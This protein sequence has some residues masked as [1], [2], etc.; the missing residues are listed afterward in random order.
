M[1]AGGTGVADSVVNQ[2]L[3]KI[4]GVEALNNVFLIG[5]TNRLDMID[6]VPCWVH[7]A[8]ASCTPFE[9]VLVL[10]P[11]QR[12]SLVSHFDPNMSFS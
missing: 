12:L 5:M 8:G 2:L 11:P 4:D 10:G 7:V 9:N 3:S 1:L 6:E